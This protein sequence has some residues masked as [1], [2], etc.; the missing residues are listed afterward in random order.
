M[1]GLEAGCYHALLKPRRG[2]RIS[3]PHPIMASA[4]ACDLRMANHMILPGILNVEGAMQKC[5]VI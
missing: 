5:A 2:A 4:W 1:I 3:S